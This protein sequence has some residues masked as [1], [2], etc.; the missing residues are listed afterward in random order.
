MPIVVVVGR[1]DEFTPVEDAELIQARVP[2]ATLVVIQAAGHM[3]NLERPT[4]FN[5][6]I[7]RTPRRC[8]SATTDA[9]GMTK[10]DVTVFITGF[11]A[12]IAR[13]YAADGARVM[14]SVY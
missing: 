9:V 14:L 2:G 1:N 7:A 4:E 12:A 6:R 5:A 11:G 13:R 10:R 3:P 8:S